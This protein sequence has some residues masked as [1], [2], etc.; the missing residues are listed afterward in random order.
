MSR[1]PC[2]P[3]GIRELNFKTTINLAVSFRSVVIC[4]KAF[5]WF[6]VG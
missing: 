4:T 6:T 1:V 5:E 3:K 2:I